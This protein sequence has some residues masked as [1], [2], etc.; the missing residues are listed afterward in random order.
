MGRREIYRYL[1][2]E[3]QLKSVWCTMCSM[4]QRFVVNCQ[5]HYEVQ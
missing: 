4:G 5:H 2:R 3:R 1:T